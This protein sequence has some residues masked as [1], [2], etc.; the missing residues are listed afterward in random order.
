MLQIGGALSTSWSGRSALPVEGKWSAL[1]GTSR[2]SNATR[3]LLEQLSRHHAPTA[4]HS[5]RVMRVAVAMWARAPDRLGD[6]ETLLIGGALHDIGKLFV[7]ATTLD[8]DR[9][10]EATEREMIR[11][12]PEAGAAVLHKLGFSPQVVSAARDHHERWGGGG[13]PSGCRAEGMHP[14][15]PA[16]AVADSYVAMIEP[17]RHYRKRMDSHAALQEIMACRGTQFDPIA[18]DLLVSAMSDQSARAIDV[19]DD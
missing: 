3:A 13:Y 11:R 15:A 5:I 10:L 9:P 6:A 18:A 16:I 14:L 12:H 19:L 2:P 7:P 1:L 8:S 4:R 17:G